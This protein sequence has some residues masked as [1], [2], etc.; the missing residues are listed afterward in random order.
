MITEC[1]PKIMR[2]KLIWA[3]VKILQGQSRVLEI[4]E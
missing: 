1:K 2:G 3:A 4:R